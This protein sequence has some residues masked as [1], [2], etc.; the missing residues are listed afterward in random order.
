MKVEFLADGAEA[1]PLI[2]LFDPAQEELERLFDRV[3]KL[4]DN[5]GGFWL[6]SLK[7]F[8]QTPLRIKL[9]AAESDT[10]VSRSAASAEW[11]WELT[12]QSW[13]TVAALIE[14]FAS[15]HRDGAY[16]WLTGPMASH[17]LDVGETSVLLSAS[18][19]GRW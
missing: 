18:R 16:Q 2:R 3:G 4:A 5:G 15:D 9:I 10:G 7:G 14:P 19:D 13:D 8:D 1:C 6:H 11:T 12:P 17:G